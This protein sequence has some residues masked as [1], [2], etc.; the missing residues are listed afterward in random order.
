MSILSLPIANHLFSQFLI[1]D[2]PT[3]LRPINNFLCEAQL[4]LKQ[5]VEATNVQF[6]TGRKKIAV[7]AINYA[8]LVS[9]IIIREI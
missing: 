7:H 6:I 5:A 9:N 4:A 2:I 1:A 8:F 3:S